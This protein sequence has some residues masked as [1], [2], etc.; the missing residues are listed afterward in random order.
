[1]LTWKKTGSISVS[2]YIKNVGLKIFLTSFMI[3]V[4]F[5]WYYQGSQIDTK[6]ELC[7][8]MITDVQPVFVNYEEKGK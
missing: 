5:L 1:M 8:G 4:M 2:N 6:N 3:T 7:A